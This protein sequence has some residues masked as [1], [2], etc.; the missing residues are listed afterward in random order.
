MIS[1]QSRFI[2]REESV[3]ERLIFL[4]QRMSDLKIAEVGKDK[5]YDTFSL[6]WL[7]KFVNWKATEI[8]SVTRQKVIGS[9]QP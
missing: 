5:E 7:K 4:H 9:F 2:C 1:P 8:K 6:K 3:A